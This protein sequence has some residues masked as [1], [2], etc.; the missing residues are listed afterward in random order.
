MNYGS[1]GMKKKKKNL[2]D[3]MMKN[4]RKPMTGYGS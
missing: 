1:K 3:S 2:Y 4:K